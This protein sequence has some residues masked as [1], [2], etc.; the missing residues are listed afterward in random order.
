M[1]EQL[2]PIKYGDIK[3]GYYFWAKKGDVWNNTRHLVPQGSSSTLCGAPMLGNNYAKEDS[4][5]GLEVGCQ[6][7]LTIYNETV[8]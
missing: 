3:S 8:S 2:A 6:K 4:G 7:C 5:T 1:S